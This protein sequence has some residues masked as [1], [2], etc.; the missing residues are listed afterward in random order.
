MGLPPKV[1]EKRQ[2]TADERA[3]ARDRLTKPRNDDAWME[4]ARAKMLRANRKPRTNTIDGMFSEVMPLCAGDTF[5]ERNAAIKGSRW[6][7]Q[8]FRTGGKLK[9]GQSGEGVF[10]SKCP[11]LCIGDPYMDNSE[12][13][14]KYNREMKKKY[15]LKNAEG[16]E[17]PPFRPSGRTQRR[18]DLYLSAVDSEMSKSEVRKAYDAARKAKLLRAKRLRQKFKD[19][20]GELPTAPRNFYT[21]PSKKGSYGVVGITLSEKTPWGRKTLAYMHDPYENRRLNAR[22][23]KAALIAKRGDR[24]PFAV[25]ACRNDLASLSRRGGSHTARRPEGESPKGKAARPGSAPP[26]RRRDGDGDGDELPPWRPSNSG[27]TSACVSKFPAWVSDPVPEAKFKKRDADAVEDPN[28][29]AWMPCSG[30]KTRVSPSVAINNRNIRA[31][32]NYRAAAASRAAQ[33][34]GK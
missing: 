14:R 23:E 11:R 13:R 5:R 10:L 30:H 9:K 29:K 7:G 21:E 15:A 25:R 24:P 34:R 8:R 2:A 22:K 26:R 18:K 16:E 3:A 27:K 20:D 12:R 6:K 17:M 19:N 33:S 1:P 31:L 28:L 32:S 4:K